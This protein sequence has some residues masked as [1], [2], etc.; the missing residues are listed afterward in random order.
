MEKKIDGKTI[1]KGKII[2]VDVDDVLVEEKGL[3]AKREIVRHNGGVGVLCIVDGCILLVRQ[4]RYA[5]NEYTLEIPAGKIEIGE[6][7]YVTGLRE[8]QEETGYEA[9]S[10]KLITRSMATPGYCTERIH[11]YEAINLKKMEQRVAMDEDEVIDLV[12]VPLDEAYEMVLNGQITDAKTVIAI[13][14]AKIK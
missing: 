5:F 8:I 6:D 9:E 14:Y 2:T 4:Y 11:I 12:K 3:K 13:F 7:P 10:L 1:Y